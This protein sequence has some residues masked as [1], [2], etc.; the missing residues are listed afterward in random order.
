LSDCSLAVEVVARAADG[1]LVVEVAETRD[2]Y[3]VVSTVVSLATL[4]LPHRADP[5]PYFL[6]L[7]DPC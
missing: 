2:Q 1:H 4:V 7:T 3:L 6:K 5:Y